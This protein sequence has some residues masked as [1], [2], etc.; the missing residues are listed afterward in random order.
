MALI[1]TREAV[2]LLLQYDPALKELLFDFS[3]PHKID[4]EAYMN[5]HFTFNVPTTQFARSTGRSLTSF[6]RDLEKIFG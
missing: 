4:L 1:K 6:K 2:E 5:E 3:E